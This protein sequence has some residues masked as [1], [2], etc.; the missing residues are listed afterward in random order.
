MT[1]S[2][3]SWQEATNIGIDD[4]IS[5]NMPVVITDI[6]HSLPLMQ[7]SLDRAIAEYGSVELRVLKSTV[8]YFS[9]SDKVEREIESMSLSD[10]YIKGILNPGVDGYFYTLGRSPIGQFDGF[11][12]YMTLPRSLAKFVYGRFRYPEENIW[13]SP[14][15]TRTALHFDAVE[16]LNLQI[17]GSKDFFLFPPRIK[18]MSPYPWYSQA[19][20]VS[21]IDPRSNL[22]PSEFPVDKGIHVELHSGQML[23]LPYGWWHQ[24]DTT[25]SSN[26]NAN[27]W[28]FPRTKLL[29]YPQQT[30][31]GAAVLAN[32]MGQHPHKRAEKLKR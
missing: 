15:G 24:V 22:S 23:Y 20:Y 10:F 3:I 29:T 7:W 21:D 31:R 25:G 8:Q 30:L 17:D 11:S 16:N 14:Q 27:F 13:I 12:D 5:Q 28:W 1:V 4:F 19:A 18:D 32:R 26:M 2:T 9:Y 6:D